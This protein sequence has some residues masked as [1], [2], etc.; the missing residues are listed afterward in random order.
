MVVKVAVNGYGTIGK[1][2]ARAVALQPDMAVVGVVKNRPNWEALSAYK[3]GFPLYV[4]EDRVDVFEKA[5]LRIEGTLRELL[6]KADVV[7]D[8]TPGGVGAK[9]KPLYEETGIKAIFQGGEDASIAEVSFNALANYDAAIGKRFVRVVSCNTTGLIRLI[10]AMKELGRIRSVRAVLVR[11]GADTKEIKKGPIEGLI[12]KPAK[13]PSHH[14]ED[15]KTVIGDMDIVTYAVIAPT[16]LAHMHLVRFEL[17]ESVTREDVLGAL[18]ATPRI[19]L[20]NASLLSSTAELREAFRDS[21]RPLGDIYENAVWEDSVWV[22]GSEVWLAQAVHQE[23]I[24]VPE[25]I[26]AIRAV[27]NLSDKESSIRLTNETLG[28]R[29]WLM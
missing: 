5:G 9:Y 25:N 4:P 3:L 2:V 21:G 13:P 17:E 29:G 6:E 16:T 23:A 28:I 15:V 19:M 26:D 20:V 11:R 27:M 24:V 7:V 12:L 14:A 10:V 22:N 1:R 8:A 18:K